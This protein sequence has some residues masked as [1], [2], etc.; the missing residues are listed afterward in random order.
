M[1][2][3]PQ[4]EVVHQDIPPAYKQAAVTPRTPLKIGTTTSAKR[5]KPVSAIDAAEEEM[6]VA[7]TSRK[8]QSPSKLQSPRVQVPKEAPKTPSPKLG[9]AVSGEAP[10]VTPGTASSEKAKLVE[11]LERELELEELE[12]GQRTALEELELELSCLEEHVDVFWLAG[13]EEIEDTAASL[14]AVRAAVAELSEE[15]RTDEVRQ[16]MRR[17]Q[18]SSAVQAG[19]LAAA[20]AEAA[21][22]ALRQLASEKGTETD[23]Q[24]I[25]SAV[26]RAAPVAAREPLTA[27]AE[28]ACLKPS[29]STGLQLQLPRPEEE[30]ELACLPISA[31][32]RSLQLGTP[33]PSAWSQRL[34]A[35]VEVQLLQEA[36]DL[37]HMLQEE[38]CYRCRRYDHLMRASQ[39]LLAE[40]SPRNTKAAAAALTSDE[41]FAASPRSTGSCSSSQTDAYQEP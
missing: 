1:H 14:S 7:L 6:P 22:A 19:H 35:T 37:Q 16:A 18:S 5:L 13:K 38:R 2:G 34:A 11:T 40:L 23:W 36:T 31:V 8:L 17:K 33:G 39:D 20:G 24:R 21:A 12:V 10:W 30:A 41:V 28:S 29:G 25:T 9:S 4:E 26:E 32:A 3:P 27:A 15:L